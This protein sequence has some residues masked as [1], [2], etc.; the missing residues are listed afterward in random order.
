MVVCRPNKLAKFPASLRFFYLAN[1]IKTNHFYRPLHLNLPYF[2]SIV[3]VIA[4][5]II[6]Y[7]SQNTQ[8]ATPPKSLELDSQLNSLPAS[9]ESRVNLVEQEKVV[10]RPS[11]RPSAAPTAVDHFHFLLQDDLLC[12]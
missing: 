7:F 1:S 5:S 3:I 10:G 11:V 4:S 12:F 6:I 9:L 8:R 2:S